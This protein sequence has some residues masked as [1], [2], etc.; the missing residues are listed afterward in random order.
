MTTPDGWRS[1][2][3]HDIETSK[4]QGHHDC[5]TPSSFHLS[6]HDDE[7]R[8]PGERGAGALQEPADQITKRAAADMEA[9]NH[10][11][12]AL[13]SQDSGKSTLDLPS[14][15]D[16][17]VTRPNASK[18]FERVRKAREYPEEPCVVPLTMDESRHEITTQSMENLAAM[19]KA[20]LNI[21]NRGSGTS[22]GSGYNQ[23]DYS[24][25]ETDP[26]PSHDRKRSA[27]NSEDTGNSGDDQERKRPKEVHLKQPEACQVQ[28][29][30]LPEG[31][32]KGQK[33]ELRKRKK[34][35]K[36]GDPFQS[37]EDQWRDVYKILFPND[38]EDLIP[39]PFYEGTLEEFGFHQNEILLDLQQVICDE[40]PRVVQ[41]TLEGRGALTDATSGG[42]LQHLIANSIREAV[43]QIFRHYNQR[44]GLHIATKPQNEQL[45]YS[46]IDVNDDALLHNFATDDVPLFTQRMEHREVVDG[47]F[48]DSADVD[49]VYSWMEGTYNDLDSSDSMNFH[50][51]D[52]VFT[53]LIG[54]GSCQ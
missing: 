48:G 19:M 38:K 51:D 53:D 26:V 6:E 43:P 27:N 11:Q 2:Q 52:E 22:S 7:E 14:Q 8:A 42:H 25:N 35:S 40:L 21:Q 4:I 32:T 13:T 15:R 16:R 54:Y 45:A 39:S 37:E 9:S 28:D 20:N 49:E 17:G 29:G 46:G 1:F 30:G 50:L 34:P 24:T 18:T 36:K 23:P 41:T 33:E 31:L 12:T 3:F 5:S 44:Q 10:T 47:V